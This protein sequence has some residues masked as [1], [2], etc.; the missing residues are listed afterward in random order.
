MTHYG[1]EVADREITTIFLGGGTPTTLPVSSLEKILESCRRN[2]SVRADAEI[3]VEANPATIPRQDLKRL[4][5]TGYNRISIGVQSFNPRELKL[6]E[7]VHSVEEVHTTVSRARSAGFD[8]LSLDLMFALPGQSAAD[9]EYSLS[10]ALAEKPEHISAYNLT[11]E[12]ETAFYKQHYNGTLKMPPDDHQL[13]LYKQ[14]IKTLKSAGYRH[15]EISNFARPGMESRHNL[16][17]WENGEYLGL[18]AGASSF[19]NGNR[20]KNHR[21]PSRYISETERRGTAVEFN[22]CPERGQA[23][24]E[25][26]MLGLRLLKGV[27][28]PQFEK[29]F[30]VSFSKTYG[31]EV[32]S[33]LQKKLISMKN[34]RIALSRKGLYLA[35]S[36]ILEFIA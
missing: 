30:D 14:A 10:Q 11:I 28:L 36:V 16:N 24:G 17:Y 32:S 12:P 22:E 25:T 9:W 31:Q 18:G 26:M 5:S 20:F 8:N 7:R 35:D 21:P 19:L 34:N 13:T 2:F 6:L 3:T 27:N 23:M 29:R 4:R 15:Y 1:K 33:L